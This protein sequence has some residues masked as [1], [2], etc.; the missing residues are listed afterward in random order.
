[1]TV[2]NISCYKFIELGDLP[3]LKTSLTSYCLALDLKGTILLAPEGINLFLAGTRPSIDGLLAYLHRD[4]R[5]TNLQ[6]KESV[7]SESPFKRLR[8]RL[9]KEIITMKQPLVRP[10]A[11]RAPSVDAATLKRWLD[12]GYDDIGRPVLM[13]DTRNDY[14]LAAGSFQGA[15]DF[16]L[17][18]FSEFPKQ[19]LQHRAGLAGKTVVS[20]CTGG[21]RCEKAAILMQKLGIQN[22]YQLEGGILKYFEQVGDAHYQ[23]NCF[24]FDARGTLDADLQPALTREFL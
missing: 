21:I 14:E 7:S 10:E 4:S 6:L 11:A 24:V 17:A 18:R 12:V 20:F 9:K 13:L 22:V 23:G 19:L 5:F 8:V 16:N 3:T 1:M 2:I 15:I